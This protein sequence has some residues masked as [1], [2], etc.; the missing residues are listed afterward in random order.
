MYVRANILERYKIIY[1]WKILEERVPNCG[2]EE[3]MTRTDQR[4]RMV[5]IPKLNTKAPK[6]VQTL[7]ESSFQV[8]GP[9]LF[10]KIPRKI[11]DMKRCSIEDFKEKLDQFL[12]TV[13]DEP[14][15]P[16]LTPSAVTPGGAPTNSLLYTI[17]TGAGES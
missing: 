2:L 8:S 3:N 12:S 11:R 10:N 9:A 6:G 17:R 16:G 13:P 5:K 15:C 14:R 1:T 4:G 7:R